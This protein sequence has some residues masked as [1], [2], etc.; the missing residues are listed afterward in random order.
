MV[1]LVYLK[2]K[3]TGDTWTLLQTLILEFSIHD[4]IF[5]I[6]WHLLSC[7]FIVTY[8]SLNVDKNVSKILKFNI[9]FLI[10]CS[11]FMKSISKIQCPNIFNKHWKLEF[12]QNSTKTRRFE[13]YFVVR[14]SYIHLIYLRFKKN[15]SRFL[16][17]FS[18]FKNKSSRRKFAYIF[19]KRLNWK[20]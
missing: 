18:T 19:Y 11:Y 10:S 2:K 5:K 4:K 14:N 12:R 8:T 9:R 16:I 6:F 20:F 15:K 17:H 3:I 13:N 7:L 1:F